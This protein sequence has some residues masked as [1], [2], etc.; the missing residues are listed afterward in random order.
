MKILYFYP[1]NPLKKT[2]GNNARAL[3]LLEYFKNRSIEIDFVGIES[4]EFTNSDILELSA[5]KLISKGY[6]LPQYKRSKNKLDYFVNYSLPNKLGKIIGL[7]DRSRSIHISAFDAI[8][9]ENTYD[10]ILI[11]YAYWSKLVENNKNIKNAKLIIDTHDFLTSQFQN[12]KEFQLGKFFEEEISILNTFDKVLVVSIEE[13]YLFSQFLS[14]K[15]EI[16]S[17]ILP[18]KDQSQL[19]K[20]YDVVYV[21]SDNEHNVKAVKWFFSE[22]Y[23]FLKPSIKIIIVGKITKHI[24][25]LNNVT[26]M[27]FVEDLDAIYL[28]SKVAI[29]P[30][31]S[32]TGIKIKVVEA[33]AFGIPVVC[34]ERGVDGL[35]NKINNGC[36]VENDSK[37]FAEA[38]ENLLEDSLLYQKTSDNAFEFFANNYSAKNN[39]KILDSVFNL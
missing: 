32:G 34:N 33:L 21:A 39:Y 13:Q 7:F 9:K 28:Q 20:I 11:S 36:M 37:K 27:N 3:S 17:H 31:L 4:K 19:E 14:N 30:M 12:R 2:Q 15:V 26:K 38:V 35:L 1:E 24:P 8:L 5:S 25:D 18:E 10:Y 6:L 29:C 16:V 23:P 22:V